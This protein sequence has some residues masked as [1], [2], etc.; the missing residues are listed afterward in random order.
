MAERGERAGIAA[1]ETDRG[2]GKRRRLLDVGARIARPAERGPVHVDPGRP[3]MGQREGRLD[4][5]RLVEKARRALERLAVEP[6]DQVERAQQRLIG[7]QRLGR[8]AQRALELGVPDAGRDARDRVGDDLV[9]HGEDLADRDVHPVGPDRLAAAGVAELDPDA[10]PAGRAPYASGHEVAHAERAPEVAD[11]A[12][13]GAQAERRA[14]RYHRELM[15]AR[16]RQDDVLHDAV[17]EPALVGRAVVGERQHRD[18]GTLG[19]RL[20]RQ[21]KS[22]RVRK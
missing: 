16:E 2:L 4:L 12:A 15:Q 17:G 22:R 6:G 19:R 10:Q 8:L 3:R 20:S 7:R 21:L 14:A 18:R 1:V 13:L 11:P 5:A 9:L